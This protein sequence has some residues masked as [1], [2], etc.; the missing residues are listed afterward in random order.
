MRAPDQQNETLGIRV[1]SWATRLE[2]VAN[3]NPDW[4]AGLGAWLIEAD[5]GVLSAVITR[6]YTGLVHLRDVPG[7][8]QPAYLHL[9]LGGRVVRLRSL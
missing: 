5:R 7:Q 9:P 2:G 8:T 3:V 4:A 6:W 1:W